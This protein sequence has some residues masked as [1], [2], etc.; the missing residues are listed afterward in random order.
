MEGNI[1]GVR[2]GKTPYTAYYD[3]PHRHRYQY[4]TQDVI[5]NFDEGKVYKIKQNGKCCYAD[6]TDPNTGQP[7]AM[8]EIQPTSKAKDMGA[9][10]QGEDW[11]QKTNLI[12]FKE[13]TDWFLTSTNTV[14]GWYQD[15]RMGKTGDQW[16]TLDV[17]YTN[18][19][20]G[21]LTDKDFPVPA[22]CTS[23]CLMTEHEESMLDA[24]LGWGPEE[25]TDMPCNKPD[26][27]EDP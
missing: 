5:Y 4:D 12:V 8:I 26:D 22:G 18:T 9:K 25:V 20:V 14:A 11:E 24:G 27:I 6:N 7:K 16:M 15:I 2:P 17:D 10:P 1:P 23:T 13:T 21:G 19:V 3:Y